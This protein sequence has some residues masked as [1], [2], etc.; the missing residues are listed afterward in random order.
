MHF[1][2]TQRQPNSPTCAQTSLF[3][4]ASSH[5]LLAVLPVLHREEAILLPHAQQFTAMV[6]FSSG[7]RGELVAP[8]PS[9]PAEASTTLLE[10]VLDL[11][12]CSV[13]AAPWAVFPSKSCHVK[14]PPFSGQRKAEKGNSHMCL[15]PLTKPQLSTY[16]L[17]ALQR[18]PPP[19]QPHTAALVWGAN[20]AHSHPRACGRTA[21]WHLQLTRQIITPSFL[22]LEPK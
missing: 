5:Q 20:G 1:I 14:S 8:S 10:Q 7:I 11:R 21:P 2:G 13:P 3:T 4:K 19:Q 18:T 6:L 9:A 15:V 16:S 17:S 12:D 22:F